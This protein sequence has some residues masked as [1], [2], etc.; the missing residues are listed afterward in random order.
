MSRNCSV[1]V[2][3]G[4]TDDQVEPLFTVRN[5][6]PALPLA[7]AV[8]WSTAESPRRRAVEPVGVSCQERVLPPPE[9]TASDVTTRAASAASRRIRFATTREPNRPGGKLGFRPLA[10]YP[11]RVVFGGP[12]SPVG[13]PGTPSRPRAAPPLPER[14]RHRGRRAGRL[15]RGRP[16]EDA[17]PLAPRTST[18]AETQREYE[19]GP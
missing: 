2:P 1:A 11:G 16:R 8:L 3:G 5:T 9:A 14:A 6:V 12:L 19:I 15:R 7:Q 13:G 17:R 18:I 10:A 4:P